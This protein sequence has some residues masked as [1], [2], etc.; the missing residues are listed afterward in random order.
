MRVCTC[1]THRRCGPLH[2]P[3]VTNVREAS[4]WL[5]YTY[6]YTRMTQN[7][8]AYGISW[9]ELSADPPL[10]GHRWG[11]WC[12]C[13]CVCVIRGT[14]GGG[15]G[16]WLVFWRCVGPQGAAGCC[17]A[18]SGSLWGPQG[19]RERGLLPATPSTAPKRRG[20][21]PATP[22]PAS[23]PRR[24]KLI[25]EAAR[26]LERSKMARFD[27]RSGNLYVTGGCWFEQ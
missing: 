15:G 2:P 18:V 17:A 14:G 26:E 27:E 20:L 12:V 22:L 9:E 11:L 19:A 1:L 25:T 16:R 23:Q 21:S 24:R 7:P 3:Q 10:E 6:L 13:V 4:Q 5:S 8:L